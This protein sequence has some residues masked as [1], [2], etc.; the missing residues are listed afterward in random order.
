MGNFP[1][2]CRTHDADWGD[3]KSDT[4]VFNDRF[5]LL[6]EKTNK[7]LIFILFFYT[8][9]KH[10]GSKR[11]MWKSTLPLLGIFSPSKIKELGSTI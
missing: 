3:P 11:Y 4:S 10:R 8:R 5:A 6:K 2:T 1:L 7:Q 9:K